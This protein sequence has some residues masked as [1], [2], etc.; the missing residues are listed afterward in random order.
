MKIKNLY[1][2][3]DIYFGQ[4]RQITKVDVVTSKKKKGSSF[5]KSTIFNKIDDNLV[6]DIKDGK[7][8]KLVSINDAVYG[9]IGDK[10]A[11]DLCTLYLDKKL[12]EYNKKII[13]KKKLKEYFEWCIQ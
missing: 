3:D 11:T 8:Y 1:F 13:T 7:K 6:E 2:V 10:F 5:V 12:S 4:I 9:N